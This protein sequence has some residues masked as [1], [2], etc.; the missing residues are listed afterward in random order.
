[1]GGYIGNSVVGVEHPSKSA[2]NA[3][4]G[5]FTGAVDIDGSITSSAGATIT[6]ADNNAQLTLK[7]TDADASAGPL[8]NLSRDNSSAADNDI[9]GQVQFNAD[10]DGNNQ[11]TYGRIHTVIE[12]A[13]N[14]SEDGLMQIHTNVAGTLRDRIK[15]T[16]SEL[17]LNEESIDS[18]FRV[19][20]NGNANMINVDAGNDLVGIGGVPDT[21]KLTVYGQV[22]TTNG[23]EGAPT[24]SFYSDTD[25][26]MFRSGGNTLAFSTGG[27]TRTT[28]DSSGN[29]TIHDGNLIIGT[30]GHGISFAA[31]GNASGM[32]NELLND[33]EEGTWTPTF[34]T[35]YPSGDPE[36]VVSNAAY[37]KIGNTVV[38]VARIQARNDATGMQLGGLP[39]NSN[40][41][42]AG[43]TI[44]HDSHTARKERIFDGNDHINW[45]YSSTSSSLANQ[46]FMIVYTTNS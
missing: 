23:T 31:D 14:G 11:T 30:S 27:T 25:T 39:F 28:V 34:D 17:V 38:A 2:L 18:D 21:S 24:H 46:Y 29:L 43:G 40:S 44:A 10:D 13:S 45:E 16:S 8:L 5:D 1:M 22:G 9:V 26:G 6:T 19:E 41:D 36:E 37:T 20:S 7:S 35:G 12:D 3:T 32:S 4:T 33:Y 15:I 42:Q